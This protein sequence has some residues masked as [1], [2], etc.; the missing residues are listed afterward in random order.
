MPERFRTPSALTFRLIR[1]SCG[2]S[3]CGAA[4]RPAC[5]LCASSP[6]C[7][8][9]KICLSTR[10]RLPMTSPYRMTLGEYWPTEKGPKTDLTA[11]Y[12]ML[13]TIRQRDELLFHLIYPAVP[14]R[15]A[16]LPRITLTRVGARS[17][18]SRSSRC[19]WGLMIIPHCWGQDVRR[20]AGVGHPRCLRVGLTFVHRDD[21][22]TDDLRRY[23]LLVSGRGRA[24]RRGTVVISRCV[25]VD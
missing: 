17:S 3:R 4:R 15:A 8:R 6:D 7:P 13:S 9:R 14:H 12:Q 11:S 22:R 16:R 23:A 24:S 5:I 2:K 10:V 20:I 19:R 25:Q 21:P 1:W 18:S